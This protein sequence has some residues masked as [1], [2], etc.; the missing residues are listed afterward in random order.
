LRKRRTL[1]IPGFQR[2]MQLGKPGANAVK[3]VEDET[4]RYAKL[5]A[6]L[7]RGVITEM[8]IAE[9]RQIIRNTQASRNIRYLLMESI[10]EMEDARGVSG[11]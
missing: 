2:G 8:E 9:L 10:S 3:W 1:K 11:T 6:K 5:S 7:Q 4:E